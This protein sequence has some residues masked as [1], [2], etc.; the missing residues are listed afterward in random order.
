M[1]STDQSNERATVISRGDHFVTIT[2]QVSLD[3][4]VVLRIGHGY[5]ASVDSTAKAT[6]FGDAVEAALRLLGH[7]QMIVMDLAQNAKECAS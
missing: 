6:N 7:K 5:S 3:Y 4:Q 1:S 2:R